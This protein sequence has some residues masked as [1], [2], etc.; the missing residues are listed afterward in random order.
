MAGG[1]DKEKDNSADDSQQSSGT[2]KSTDKHDKDISKSSNENVFAG[3]PGFE[4]WARSIGLNRKSTAV[5]RDEDLTSV[6]ALQ[7]IIPED[8]DKL[9]LSVGQRRILLNALQQLKSP[10]SSSSTTPPIAEIHNENTIQEAATADHGLLDVQKQA[11]VL[12]N[13]GKNFEE[14]F[15]V[16]DP[17]VSPNVSQQSPN[18]SFDPRA[19]LTSKAF[20]V[21]TIHITQFLSEKTKKRRLSRRRELVL[22]SKGQHSDQLVIKTEEDHPYLGISIDEWGGANCRLMNHLLHTGQLLRPQI[23]YY[24]AYTAQIYDFAAKYEWDSILDYDYSYREMQAEHGF[25]WGTFTSHLE[26]QVLMPK[27][28]SNYKGPNYQRYAQDC[29]L[30]KAHGACPFGA[31]CKYRHVRSF[32]TNPSTTTP[33][34]PG[35]QNNNHWSKNGLGQLPHMNAH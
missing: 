29:R 8:V 3:F 35:Q 2:S 16:K 30:F 4:E 5:L 12:L 18:G 15:S 34:T 26:L 22:S 33:Q 9:S 28:S 14:L 19:I 25:M 1:K 10:K 27:R 20:S 31:T 7:V 23:E 24:L 11:N 17:S 6:Q 32:Q 13:T 21:K